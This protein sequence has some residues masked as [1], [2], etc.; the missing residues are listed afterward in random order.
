MV[1]PTRLDCKS[2]AIAIRKSERINRLIAR[3][4]QM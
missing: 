3:A 2:V 4:M 1:G